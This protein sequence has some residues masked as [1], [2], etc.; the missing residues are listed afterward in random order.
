[1]SGYD[2]TSIP[3]SVPP[4]L[5]HH[6]TC[7]ETA[8]AANTACRRPGNLWVEQNTR[9]EQPMRIER[10]LC[11]T[12]RRGEEIGSLPGIPWPVI[13]AD[14][15][16]VGD[17]TPGADQRVARGAF[18]RLPLRQQIAMPAER[19]ECEIRGGPIRI[20]VGETAGYLPR[21]PSGLANRCFGCGF[22][23]VVKGFEPFPGNRG[24]KCVGDDRPPDQM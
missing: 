2:A 16:V 1:M 18:D 12:Q 8:V 19:V 9:I 3:S 17:G 14:R 6:S 7:G 20:D 24:L 4:D 23:R 5:R 15:V 10:A 13:A 11:C 21:A 22:D